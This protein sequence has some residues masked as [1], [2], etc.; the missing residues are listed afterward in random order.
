MDTPLIPF[1]D[2]DSP[3]P[4][5]WHDVR[6]YDDLDTGLGEGFNFDSPLEASPSP[7]PT[8]YEAVETVNGL[9]IHSY[10]A[11]VESQSRV[12]QPGNL[13]GF[14]DL[15]PSHWWRRVMSPA[16]AEP[17][18]LRPL[19][20]DCEVGA[21]DSEEEVLLD[22]TDSED[23]LR[24]KQLAAKRPV[25][26]FGPAGSG[27]DEE[28]RPSSGG[29][30][31]AEA[32]EGQQ[33]LEEEEEEDEEFEDDDDEYDP[34]AAPARPVRRAA[35][36]KQ[37]SRISAAPAPTISSRKA[38][39]WSQAEDAACIK[40]MKEVCTLDGYAA[41]AGTEKRFEVVADRMKREAGFNRTASGV[42]LQWNRR[43]RAASKFED[44]GEKKRASGLTTSALPG[45]STKHGTSAVTSLVAST[46]SKGKESSA[47]PASSIETSYGRRQN[48][49]RKAN[50]D[51]EDDDDF[52]S[53]PRPSKP[54]KRVRSTSVMS[55]SAVPSTQDLAYY[56]LS[57][58]NIISGPRSS[59]HRRAPTG[60]A[61]TITAPPPPPPP[62]PL[63]PA[64]SSRQK[65]ITATSDD[66]DEE[67][68]IPP[69][70]PSA[71]SSQ[72]KRARTIDD[73]ED[74]EQSTAAPSPKRKRFSNDDEQSTSEPQPKK[75]KRMSDFTPVNRFSNND[76]R[77]LDKSKTSDVADFYDP[78]K[79]YT[80]KISPEPALTKLAIEREEHERQRQAEEQ[81][82]E[83]DDDDDDEEEDEDPV[84]NPAERTRKNRELR[85]LMT[86]FVRPDSPSESSSTNFVQHYQTF[87]NYQQTRQ[88]FSILDCRQTF[89]YHQTL[90][91]Y[92]QPFFIHQTFSTYY[93]CINYQQTLFDR[94]QTFF[95]HQTFAKHDQSSSIYYIFRQQNQLT[96]QRRSSSTMGPKRTFFLRHTT[97]S[98]R[99]SNN[100]AGTGVQNDPIV[101]TAAAAQIAADEEMAR[102]VQGEWNEEPAPR[103]RRG[104]GFN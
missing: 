13:T 74:D 101:A 79:H 29:D 52:I 24:P 27:D 103:V 69:P 68:V 102:Q 40:F 16:S 35:G 60:E 88:I 47:T 58:E 70:K 54:A 22:E 78:R 93:V 32:P 6:H 8:D 2:F 9:D 49:K 25:G 20:C 98:P 34:E 1:A 14:D 64:R 73:D 99:W 71:R 104:R 51:D 37:P 91:G 5:G 72:Q 90:F 10:L 80:R 19:G 94:Q 38:S 53:T 7:A 85:R 86:G 65:P 67:E 50:S 76:G 92:R 48:N 4:A 43:L 59:R 44:R 12:V 87:V 95:I 45:Q 36:G 89:D 63:P 39:A 42:K 31:I 75:K 83:D 62:P 23:E 30:P 33:E 18:R 97:I 82:E 46:P 100:T 84:I 96:P 3:F 21:S 81:E 55:S 77:P 41:I 26:A 56:D 17:V 15:C 28:E 11:S 57:T 66:D 61:P